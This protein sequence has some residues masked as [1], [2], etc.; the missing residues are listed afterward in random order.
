[1]YIYIYIHI[2]SCNST[3]DHL[4]LILINKNLLT[5]NSGECWEHFEPKKDANISWL[6]LIWARQNLLE[7]AG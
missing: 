7:M 2:L 4:R 5:V 6:M 1:M 3:V